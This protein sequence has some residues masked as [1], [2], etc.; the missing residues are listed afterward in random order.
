MN[1]KCVIKLLWQNFEHLKNVKVNYK[2]IFIK[3]FLYILQSYLRQCEVDIA[4][5]CELYKDWADIW[6]MSSAFIELNKNLVTSGMSIISFLDWNGKN[7]E[8]MTSKDEEI[9]LSIPFIQQPYSIWI[10]VLISS[11]RR[12]GSFLSIFPN[13]YLKLWWNYLLSSA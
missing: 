8:L 6:N 12:N 13:R 3:D 5:F 11:L 9:S 1:I 10:P 7:K 2:S 4:R